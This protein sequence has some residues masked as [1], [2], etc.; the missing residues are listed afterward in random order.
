MQTLVARFCSLS[1]NMPPE[2]QVQDTVSPCISR[3]SQ[4]CKLLL[5]L[6]ACATSLG[7]DSIPDF[8]YKSPHILAPA[9]AKEILHCIALLN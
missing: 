2:L 8:I 6:L 1:D 3:F 9:S 5:G 4:T 7:E